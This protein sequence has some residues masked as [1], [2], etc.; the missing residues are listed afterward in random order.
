MSN[1]GDKY[2]FTLK[3]QPDSVIKVQ[4]TNDIFM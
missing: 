3:T 4:F 2:W 1:A